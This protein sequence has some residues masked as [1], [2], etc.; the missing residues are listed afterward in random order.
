MLKSHYAIGGGGISQNN[1]SLAIKYLPSGQTPV[2]N[3]YGNVGVMTMLGVDL[4]NGPDNNA[5]P[6]KVFDYRPTFTVDSTQGEIIFPTVQPFDSASI[7]YF[8]NVTASTNG[9]SP[10]QIP[11]AADSLNFNN[12]YDTTASAADVDP[13]SR[14][15]I[16][17]T[18]TSSVQSQYP[19]GSNIVEG[20][21]VVTVDGQA[22]VLNV[23]YTVD[24]VSGTVTIRNPSFLTAGRNVQIKYEA[25]DLFQLASKTL[26]GVRGE[27]DI[28]RNT[29]L[30]FT[31]MNLNEQSLTDKVRLGDEPTDNTIYGLDASTNFDAPFLTK[32]LNWLPGIHTIEKSRVSLKGEY[33]YMSPDPNTRTSPVPEDGGKSVAYIDDFE[34]SLQTLPISV[35]YTSWKE[36][37]PPYYS[38]MIDT[39]YVIDPVTKTVSTNS[40]NTIMP[41]SLKME[42]KAHTTWF[43]IASSDVQVTDIWGSRKQAVSGQSQVTVLN[44]FFDPGQRGMYNYSPNLL[45]K[46]FL[47]PTKAWGGAQLAL[48]TSTTNLSDQ[49]INY[50]QMWVKIVNGQPTVKLNIDLGYISENSYPYDG[51]ILNTEDGLDNNGTPTGVMHPDED[52][53]I[54]GLWDAD[55]RL[56]DTTFLNAYKS[57]K[58]DTLYNEYNADPSG[59]DW[60]EPPTSIGGEDD[61]SIG[62]ARTFDGCNGVEGNYA[63]ELGARYPDTE[64]LNGDGN[65]NTLNSYFEYEI[66]LDTN[67]VLFRNYVTGEGYN[68]WHQISIPLKDFMRQ[69]GTPTLTDIQNMRV[70]VTGAS[71]PVLFR[72]ANLYLVGNQWRAEIPNDTTFQVS[73]V[74]FQDNPD[75]TPPIPRVQDP[76]LSAQASQPIYE[77]EQS[78]DLILNGLKHGDPLGDSRRAVKLFSSHP[79]NLLNYHTMEMFFHG[80][81]RNVP[82]EYKAFLYTDSSHYD[83]RIAFRFGTDSLNYYEYSAPLRPDWDKPY[84]DMTIHFADLASLKALRDSTERV[85]GHVLNG[86]PGSLY[87]I[88]GSPTLSAIQYLAIEVKLHDSTKTLLGEVWVDEL[89]LTDVDNTP[90]SAYKLDANIKLADVATIGFSLSHLGPTFHSLEDQFGSRVDQ[91]SWSLASTVNFEKFLPDS[92]AGTLLA[93]SYSHSENYQRPQYVPGSDV[94]VEQAAQQVAAAIAN[95]EPV[96]TKPDDIRLASQTLI[97]TDSYALPSLRFNIPLD[98][99]LVTKTINQ[100]TFGYSYSSSFQR[101]PTIEWSKSWTWQAHMSYMIQFSPANYFKPFHWLGKFFLTSIWQDLT[102]YFTPK[103]ISTSVAFNRSQSQSQTR[104][105]DS[106]DPLVYN[107]TATRSLNFTWQWFEGRYLDLGANYQVNIGSTLYKLE[108]DQYGNQRSFYDILKDILLSDRLVN[109]GADQNY[110]QSITWNPQIKIPNTS[111]LGKLIRPSLQVLNS[112]TAGRTISLPAD[113]GKVRVRIVRSGFL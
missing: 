3:V 94:L 19:V 72:I 112:G 11:Q 51:N 60:K 58:G 20:S 30:G 55:E 76:T 6:D 68:G 1:F 41:D 26:L 5:G 81:T 107:L 85:S 24:Y 103:D 34:G 45:T 56:K 49:N 18:A 108:T 53:G 2:D 74:N 95:G 98:T 4:Y 36:G 25:N 73:A 83:V 86:P 35:A 105:Q 102:I 59:D 113:W 100:I 82:N 88:V 47:N 111:W 52:R 84:N 39:A 14:Y 97:V 28:D 104:Y 92:W 66:P 23:D 29:T 90:G 89:R 43:T 101:S 32:A 110:S 78:L 57:Y 71:A 75:Y 62:I 65:L 70:W 33:A 61:L 93:M 22:A 38:S 27:F 69:I 79:I 9:L 15:L 16:T 77:N 42:Y 17:G 13:R 21:V 8:L 31:V 10:A 99:W 7:A 12:L 87:A 63:S 91:L 46:L 50:I 54:D 64:D 48:A 37:S 96:N 109:F 44:M 40:V 106:P 67:N 80:E